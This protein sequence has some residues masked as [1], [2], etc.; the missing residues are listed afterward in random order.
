MGNII[1]KAGKQYKEQSKAI[2]WV[3][4][5]EDLSVASINGKVGQN[6]E[7]GVDLLIGE[8]PA[9]PEARNAMVMEVF[10]SKIET[11]E[12]KEVSSTDYTVKKNDNLSTIASSH[13]I[14]LDKLKADNG[15]TSDIIQIGQQLKIQEEKV[16][17][18]NLLLKP[19]KKVSVGEELLLVAKTAGLRQ[20]KVSIQIKQGKEKCIKEIGQSLESLENEEEKTTFE[21]NVGAFAA[22]S[23]YLN[24]TDYQD[25]AIIKIQLR[26]TDEAMLEEW[27]KLLKEKST[28]SAFL[29]FEVEAEADG[30]V[31]YNGG[32]DGDK[33]N[34][35]SYG[36]GLWTE[37][38]PC[39]CCQYRIVNNL[40]EGPNVITT[41]TGSKVTSRGAMG[42]V[43]AIILHRTVGSTTSSAVGHSKGTHFYIDGP[44]GSDGEIFQPFDLTKS[45]SHIL[46]GTNADRIARTDIDNNNSI[47]IEVVGMAYTQNADGSFQTVY[48][49][50]AKSDASIADG[51]TN[52][53]GTFYWDELSE[54]QIKSVTCVVKTLIKHFKLT[55]DDVL[56]HEAI[57]KKTAGEG[58]TVLDAIKDN[59]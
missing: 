11:R 41:K 37:A 59:L 48:E 56:T 9:R 42:E 57:Q 38:F 47:G 46:S 18:E 13:N 51:Y 17:G 22:A 54:K 40:L 43:K 15:L 53:D 3:S 7:E 36:D 12:I 58:T 52:T 2:T 6:G 10:F 1:F 32:G 49:T 29:Y 55:S 14:E 23:E 50:N 31:T 25:T 35:F 8:A 24:K 16:K 4:H 28:K 34:L 39:D 19:L 33:K 20:K 44:G 5:D 21:T 30:Q 27:T 45:S 26:P